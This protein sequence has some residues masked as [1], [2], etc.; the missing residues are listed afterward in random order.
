V[1]RAIQ[2]L[3]AEVRTDMAML[4]IKSLE[5]LSRAHLRKMGPD[6]F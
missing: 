3:A 5:Q 6:P 4:G 2:L 1:R